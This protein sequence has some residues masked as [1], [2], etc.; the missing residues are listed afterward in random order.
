[1][2]WGVH[3]VRLYLRGLGQLPL[4]FQICPAAMYTDSCSYSV[5]TPFEIEREKRIES[6]K[7]RLL[8]LGL[9]ALSLAVSATVR[10]GSYAS[11][12][13]A[14]AVQVTALPSR[15]STRGK[16]NPVKQEVYADEVND[17][18]GQV[19][20]TARKRP[21]QQQGE[22]SELN[23]YRVSTMSDS[24]LLT[25]I[26]RIRNV[27]KMESFIQVLEQEGKPDLADIAR[28]ALQAL[29]DSA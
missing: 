7:R 3:E 8:E 29:L 21:A 28:N 15:R 13:V 4:V 9:P 26:K 14:A 18:S 6:N 27:R 12:R 24:A 22:Y 5:L 23:E 17:K 11:G 2:V 10:S 1:M 19:V 25:R 16:A 20:R